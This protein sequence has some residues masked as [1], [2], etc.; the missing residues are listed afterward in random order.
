[1]ASRRR[2]EPPE[3]LLP[4]FE[5][6]RPSDELRRRVLASIEPG[7]R[8]EGFVARMAKLFDLPEARR[9]LEE[10]TGTRTADDLLGHIFE[11]FCIGK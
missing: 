8:L 7:S 9:L 5:P 4:D 10:V 11:S 2:P 1:M 6:E 3:S